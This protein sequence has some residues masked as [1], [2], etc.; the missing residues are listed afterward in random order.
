MPKKQVDFTCIKCGLKF[1]C[2][3][4][5][6]KLHNKKGMCDICHYAIEQSNKNGILKWI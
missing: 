5:Q 4:S 6:L 3:P 2:L 1:S